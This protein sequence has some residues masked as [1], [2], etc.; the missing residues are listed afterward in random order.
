MGKGFSFKDNENQLYNGQDMYEFIFPILN[1]ENGKFKFIGTGFFIQGHGAFI[2]AKHV[3][4]NNEGELCSTL[5]ILHK[6]HGENKLIK[7]KVHNIYTNEKSDIVICTPQAFVDGHGNKLINPIVTL[8]SKKIEI[9]DQVTT[10][11]CP[12]SD[13]I[14]E[15][16]I[17]NINLKLDRYDGVVSQDFPNGRDKSF[18]PGACYET[19]IEILSGA[20]GGPVFGKKNVCGVNSTGFDFADEGETPISY[21]TPI[22]EAFDISFTDEKGNEMSIRKLAEKGIVS[23]DD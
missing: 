9:G 17:I 11:A 7:R 18:L 23:I 22:T 15:N 21:I 8:S 16:K 3:V 19:T 1:L 12:N 2:T 13:I 6:I 4:Q 20:S 5:Y 10:I 14:T